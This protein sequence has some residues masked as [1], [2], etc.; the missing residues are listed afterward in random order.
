MRQNLVKTL[1]LNGPETSIQIKTIN[2]SSKVYKSILCDL[3]VSALNSD[4]SFALTNVHSIESISLQPNSIPPK[5]ELFQFQNLKEI[6]FYTIPGASIQMLIGADIPEMLCMRNTRKGPK[7]TPYPIETPLG[8][9]LLSPS[10]TISSQANFHVN[11]LSCK[12]DELLQATE[13]LLKSDFKRDTSL[14]VPNSKE[15]R[16]AYIVMESR[17]CLDGGHYQLPLL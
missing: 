11:F 8:W 5:R 16:V 10:M 7:R 4:K 1:N 15:E 2:G 3:E 17:L 13:R 14:N 6:K 12:D 9:S